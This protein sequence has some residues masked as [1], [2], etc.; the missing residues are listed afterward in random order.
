[1]WYRNRLVVLAALLMVACGAAP[2]AAGPEKVAVA[3]PLDGIVLDGDLSDWP[4]DMIHY[5]VKHQEGGDPLT[6]PEDFSGEFLVGFSAAENALYVAV[7]VHDES[8][9][10]DPQSTPDWGTQDG[11]EVYLHGHRRQRATPSQYW[12]R[13]GSVGTHGPGT[14]ADAKV[15]ADWR[16]DGYTLEWRIDMRRASAGHLTVGPEADVG[17]DLAVWDLDADGSGSW[18]AWSRGGVKYA[19][20]NRLGRLVLMQGE[21]DVADVLRR[22][23]ESA[24]SNSA[25]SVAALKR[26]VGLQMFFSG[27]LLAFTVLH[28]LLFIFD[29]STKANLFYALYTGLITAAVFVGFQLESAAMVGSDYM[30]HTRQAALVVVNFFGLCF[31]Y[32]MFSPRP[33]RRFWILMVVTA[34]LVF[35]VIQEGLGRDLALAHEQVFMVLMALSVGGVFS[36]ILVALFNAVRRN[37]EGAW[38]VGTGFTVFALNTA[39][40]IILPEPDQA[41]MDASALYWIFIPLISMSVYLARSV[42]RT[43]RVL[44]KQ[45]GKIEQLSQTTQEQYAR[46]QDQNAEIQE[47]NRL[48]SD[49]LARMSHDLRTPMNAIIGYTRILL[50][51]TRDQLDQRQYR[52]LENVGIS[53]QNLLTL[54]NDILDISKIESGRQEIT[55]QDVDLGVLA[56]ECAASVESLARPGVVVQHETE[57]APTVRTDPDRIRRVLMNLLSNAVKFTDQGTVTVSVQPQGEWSQIAVADTGIGI[58]PEDLPHIFDEFHQVGPADSAQ[59]EGTGLGL[60]IVRKSV[61]LLGGSVRAVSEQGR[62]SVFTVLVRDYQPDSAHG[63]DSP[64]TEA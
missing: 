14:G 17:F 51:K 37:R 53:A 18:V 31:L 8:V 38:I 64:D 12:Y 42:G 33:P 10:R 30:A 7:M 36:E 57:G 20:H 52:N 34:G 25:L 46:I 50:R 60:A 6:G 54:I 48:K 1:M 45:L 4:P 55:P 58:K 47:A 23:E 39:K 16:T 59:R 40:F 5:P 44:S 15:A 49:F 19:D 41:A 3:Y 2:A 21:A 22:V 11:V 28:L 43:N 61:D 62:G 9:I 35:A 27:V 56:R 26:S 32:S 24:T 29:P 13:A 63:S